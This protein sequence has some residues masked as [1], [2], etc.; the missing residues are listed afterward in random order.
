VRIPTHASGS[1]PARQAVRLTGASLA[2]LWHLALGRDG[3]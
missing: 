1:S 3:P 2:R